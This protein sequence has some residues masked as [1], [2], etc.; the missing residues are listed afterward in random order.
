MAQWTLKY[1]TVE[2]PSNYITI[3]GNVDG[4]YYYNIPDDIA[5]RNIN[6]Y[7]VDI[8]GIN[9]SRIFFYSNYTG[10]GDSFNSTFKTLY[11]LDNFSNTSN[12]TNMW[13]MFKDCSNLTT[14]SNFN[15][16]NVTDMDSMFCNCYNLTNVPNFNTSNVVDMHYM[17]ENCY[18]LIH[19]SNFDTSNVVK[20]SW[21]FRNCYNLTNVPNFNTSNVINMSY[22]FLDCYSLINI[23]NF[24]TRNVTNMSYMFKD[25][26]NLINIPN[27]DISNVTDMEDMFDGCSNLSNL[28][29]KN[30]VK[31]LPNV[32]QLTSQNSNL[33][34]I[35]LSRTQINYIST[36]KYA[37]QLQARG[38]NIEDNYVK[39]NLV[40]SLKMKQSDGTMNL[41]MLGTNAEYVDMEDGTTLEETVQNLKQYIDDNV[42]NILG[43][44]Y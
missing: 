12:V 34:N 42:A 43:G 10:Y 6:L 1:T 41:A 40:K 20:M 30:I 28:S 16:S 3:T 23:P 11:Y 9:S 5:N 24:D 26:N 18:S 32:S 36:T 31:S 27:F 33:R 17:F 35:G 39:P 37:S 2:D 44:M 7:N 14:I 29:L 4:N 21:T 25:C 22:M 15:T 13:C 38:W 8:T 19:I